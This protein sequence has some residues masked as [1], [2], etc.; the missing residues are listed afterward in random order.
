MFC[1]FFVWFYS[2]LA[3]SKLLLHALNLGSKDNQSIIIV[4][5]VDGSDYNRPDEEFLAGPFYQWSV[6]TIYV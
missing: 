1:F 4:Q 2:A 6:C 5:F 3:A